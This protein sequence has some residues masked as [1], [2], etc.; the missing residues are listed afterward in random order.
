MN[1]SKVQVGTHGDPVATPVEGVAGV[2]DVSWTVTVTDQVA[3]LTFYGTPAEEIYIGSITITA[4]SYVAPAPLPEE[5]TTVIKGEDIA[6][7]FEESGKKN[8]YATW[9]EGQATGIVVDTPDEVKAAMG[10]KIGD[11]AVKVDKSANAGSFL[12]GSDQTMDTNLYTFDV[13][14][15]KTKYI[16][17]IEIYVETLNSDSVTFVLNGYTNDFIEYTGLVEGYNSVTI[18]YASSAAKT[19]NLGCYQGD[20]AG[21]IGDITIELV[22]V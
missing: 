15:E 8:T 2:Y 16:I 13:R 3:S 10:D 22:H 7:K 17:T 6:A 5:S 4:G 19:W 21:Y 14:N 9:G 18:E 12:V 20:F 11:K 1:S